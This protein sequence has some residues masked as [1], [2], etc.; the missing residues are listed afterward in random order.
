MSS[1]LFHT[2]TPI[3]HR[4]AC[5]LTRLTFHSSKVKNVV[6]LPP[7]T[8]LPQRSPAWRPFCVPEHFKADLTPRIACLRRWAW[9]L[10]QRRRQAMRRCV[11]LK[12]S[13]LF[14]K[15]RRCGNSYFRDWKPFTKQVNMIQYILCFGSVAQLG[16]RCLRMAEVARSNR[17]GSR[18]GK[19]RQMPVLFV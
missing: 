6:G 9:S 17:V 11:A 3:F 18:L 15:S 12:C 2:P 14:S 7:A 1:R 13:T 4:Q 19:H 8:P 10:A 5:S 16:E